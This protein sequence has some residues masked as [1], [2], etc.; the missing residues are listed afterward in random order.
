MTNNKNPLPLWQFI[1]SIGGLLFLILLLVSTFSIDSILTLL[2]Q[3]LV[4]GLVATLA[5]CAFVISRSV[6]LGTLLTAV[7]GIGASGYLLTRKMAASGD[8]ICNISATLN[9]DA[10]NASAASELMG[11]PVTLFGIAFYVG[12]AV[13]ALAPTAKTPRFHQVNAI[14]GFASVLF[15]VYLGAEAMALGVGCLLCFSLYA[16][17][18][19]L[20]WAGLR[21]L[22][23]TEGNALHNVG[24]LPLSRT[25]ITITVIFIL[26]VGVFRM[27]TAPIT[28]LPTESGDKIDDRVLEQLYYA[29]NGQIVLDGT[30][31]TLGPP[32]AKYQIVEFADFGCPHCA[33]AEKALTKLITMRDDTSL[34]FKPFP[35]SGACNPALEGTDGSYLCDTAAAVDC[36]GQQGKF[37]EYS[38]TV[39]SNQQYLQPADLLFH[40]KELQLDVTLW[41]Q[42]LT[43]PATLAGI[44]RDAQAGTKA[45]VI[46]TPAIFL[47]G[48][49]GDK[50]INVRGAETVI[51]L[52][53]ASESGRA[54]PKPKQKPAR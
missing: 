46:G 7:S 38:H 30:E 1:G 32:N 11:L 3:P 39:F 47:R 28:S 41:Q 10:V 37:F 18:V 50:Y 42:C 23:Q 4:L 8:S 9:C 48:T 17:N 14:F 33:K 34:T 21:G 54:L 35:L 19:L 51:K 43:K 24:E 12:L 16:S 44:K 49:H 29:A 53:Q 6:R 25:N 27:A 15:S 52:I 5:L 45:G 40:A 31:F 2:A 22:K 20:L 26:I 36:A 13:A